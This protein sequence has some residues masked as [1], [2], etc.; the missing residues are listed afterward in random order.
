M[1]KPPRKVSNQPVEKLTEPPT[2]PKSRLSLHCSEVPWY[3]NDGLIGEVIPARKLNLVQCRCDLSM[4]ADAQLDKNRQPYYS[5]I[6][7]CNTKLG[8]LGMGSRCNKT[9]VLLGRV[10]TDALRL[11]PHLPNRR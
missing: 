4:I 7:R 5:A 9:L 8:V 6:G 11:S 1:R 10:K 2:N 3:Y